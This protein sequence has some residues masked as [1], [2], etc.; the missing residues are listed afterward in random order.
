MMYGINHA[1]GIGW[2]WII[3]FIVVMVVSSL[4]VKV[5]NQNYNRSNQNYGYKGQI[6]S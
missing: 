5:V 2:G 3:G 6:A 1:W 4:I